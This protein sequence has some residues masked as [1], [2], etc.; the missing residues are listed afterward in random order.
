MALRLRAMT[1]EEAGAARRLAHARTEPARVVGRARVVWLAGEGRRVPAIAAEVRLS[2]G[3]VR[4]WVKRFNAAG[5]DGLKDGPRAGRPPT[6]S[7]AEV[8]EV[9]ATSLTNPRSLGLPFASWTLDR[10]TAYLNE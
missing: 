2:E 7:E 5:V 4:H 9:V 3:T 10:L 1:D 8:G 6:Y